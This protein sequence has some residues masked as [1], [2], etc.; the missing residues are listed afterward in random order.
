ME[1][2]IIASF[3]FIVLLALLPAV[4]WI[5]ILCI[6]EIKEKLNYYNNIKLENSN[7]IEEIIAR[8]CEIVH[9]NEHI[10]N[11]KTNN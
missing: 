9:L 1:K 11:G 10:K 7:L 5:W 4:V 8:D 3:M 6:E 2:Y